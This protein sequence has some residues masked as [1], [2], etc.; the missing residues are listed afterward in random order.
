MLKGDELLRTEQI[1][2]LSSQRTIF[3][4]DTGTRID[5]IYEAVSESDTNLQECLLSFYRL[6]W[7]LE[8][9][10]SHDLLTSIELK[11]QESL[12][13]MTRLVDVLERV[14]KLASFGIS[15]S[16]YAKADLQ[17][18]NLELAK[19][20]SNRLQDIDNILASTAKNFPAVAPICNFYHVHQFQI[21]EENPELTA[22]LTQISYERIQIQ[23]S[24][25]L[26]LISSLI[27]SKKKEKEKRLSP[28]Q[29][30][31]ADV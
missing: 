30:A 19:Q 25:I 29:P 7:Q 27:I 14:H 20:D 11:R 1:K 12:D 9:N 3:E 13:G 23:V 4:Q 2:I 18:N 22:A 24:A 28:E 31:N 10:H 16:R 6:I 5:L 21:R 15:Y 17:Q 8:L 26:E